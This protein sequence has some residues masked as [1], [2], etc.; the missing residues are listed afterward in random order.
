M[1]LPHEELGQEKGLNKEEFAANT[2]AKKKDQGTD[3][4]TLSREREMVKT[5]QNSLETF[6][7]VILNNYY[8]PGREA[9]P[10]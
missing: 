3:L 10:S 4:P 6:T 5:R 1:T 7:R 2:L 9:D 8:E